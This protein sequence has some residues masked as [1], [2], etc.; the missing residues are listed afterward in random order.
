MSETYK[1][2]LSDRHTAM[3]RLK[4]AVCVLAL[5]TLRLRHVVD[6]QGAAFDTLAAAHKAA[7]RAID[8]SAAQI[9]T[10]TQQFQAEIDD[11]GG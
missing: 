1:R 10:V 2:L 11:E 3:L 7:T 6:G 4:V 8:N 9:E 5:Q